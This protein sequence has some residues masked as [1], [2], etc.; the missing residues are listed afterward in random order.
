MSTFIEMVN[1]I[2]DDLDRTDLTTQVKRE[3]N[4]AIRKYSQTRFWFNEDSST[5]STVVDQQSYSSADG[6]ATDIKKIIY[7]RL[8]QSATNYYEIDPTDINNILKWN[9]NDN[10][11]LP[12]VY[13]WFD[14]K[15]FLYPN[16]DQV[17]TVTYYYQKDYV[18]LSADGDTNDWTTNSEAEQ[19]IEAETKYQLYKDIILDQGQA[20]T[21]KLSVRE[22]LQILRYNN[23]NFMNSNGRVEATSF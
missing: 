17:Y 23:T 8:T 3:I 6:V 12:G 22:A 16:P 5:F 11:G 20:Q 2:E 7:M 13:A 4:R 10:P 15:I 18:D 14:E 21:C 19:L 1:K 9:A